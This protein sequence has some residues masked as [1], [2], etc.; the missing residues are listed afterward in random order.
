MGSA[1]RILVID[2]ERGYRDSLRVLLEREGFK[3]EI[4][5]NGSSALKKMDLEIFDLFLVDICM[6]GM[7]GFHLLECI[8]ERDPDTPVVMMT[9]QATIDSA[10]L[11]LKK[12]AY[13]YLRK[14]FEHEDLIK[15][16]NNTLHKHRLKAENRAI[17][18]QLELSEKR[19][20]HIV[21]NSPDIIY[22][23]DLEGR[24]TF[25]NEAVK[26]LLD[27]DHEDLLGKPFQSIIHGEDLEKSQ[28][29]FQERRTGER[30]AS[31]IEIRLISLHTG[32]N[33]KHFVIRHF[34]VPAYD[35]DGMEP[36]LATDGFPFGI[37]GVARDVSYRRLLEL[38]LRES[39]KMEAIGTLAGGIAHD[40]NNLLMCIQGYTSLMLTGI[41]SEHLY[42][43]KLVNIE[44]NVQLGAELTSQLLGFARSGKYHPKPIDLNGV[45]E[46]TA[47][48]F[49]RTKKQI[50]I[51][52]HLQQGLWA[53]HA[54]EGQIE[55]VLLNLYVN[56]WQAMPDGG[57][58]ILE[59]ENVTLPKGMMGE[60]GLKPGKYVKIIIKDTGIGMEGEIQQRI[61]DPFF[62]TKERGR[63]TGLGLASAY[64]IISNHGGA[65]NVSSK[66]GQGS[67]F[68]FYLPMTK[69]KVFA[70]PARL[71]EIEKGSETVLLVDDEDN[72]LEVGKAMLE[73]MGY[74]VLV[75]RNGY[76][77][78]DVFQTYPDKIDLMILDMIMPGLGG[79]QTFDR[80]KDIDSNIKVLLSSGYSLNGEA[81]EILERGCDGFIQKPYTLEELSKKIS[82]VLCEER[83]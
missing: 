82:E 67:T 68:T 36:F 18:K 14:P 11:A 46:R 24:F 5:E 6:P 80:I 4:C 69:E 19:Y 37:Y 23:L 9:G 64:G 43:D 38:Q 78:L 32:E 10:V 25:V 31:G 71:H 83:V 53:A 59:T 34:N 12:G 74:K 8:M 27:Y 70:P 29:L 60:I 21:Q 56:A 58:I 20:R 57:D 30:A 22:T 1:S 44:R 26:R 77:A 65:F 72:I 39:Q 73:N 55:Q 51:R 13:D 40:F 79:G 48:M 61:F 3:A 45:L 76:E 16:I 75:A 62:T 2:D 41:E 15:T 7:D 49:G 81:E 47:S 17:Q 35:Q 28:W 50:T 33:F 63:G 54:D 52:Y 42:Y 66:K